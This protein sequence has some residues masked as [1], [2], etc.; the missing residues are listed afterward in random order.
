MLISLTNIGDELLKLSEVD[1]G[2]FIAISDWDKTALQ[3][4]ETARLVATIPNTGYTN[5]YM[6]FMQSLSPI[7]SRITVQ[8]T[9]AEKVAPGQIQSLPLNELSG[10]VAY[11]ISP[12]SNN[13]TYHNVTLSAAD[14]PITTD[15]MPF[16]GT[17][18]YIDLYSSALNSDFNGNIGSIAF[19]IQAL[20]LGV[21]SDLDF[22]GLLSLMADGDSNLVS[23]YKTNVTNLIIVEYISGGFANSTAIE[24]VPTISPIH[25]ALTWVNASSRINTYVNGELRVSNAWNPGLWEGNLD[26]TLC[27]LGKNDFLGFVGWEGYISQYRLY[28]RELSAQEVFILANT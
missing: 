7:N 9:Y 11:D 2:N 26:P 6:D 5:A 25:I 23:I 17:N 3:P 16:F 20:N 21:W 15:R 12:E 18:G 22:M 14:S 1:K 8:F 4:N 10:S 19:F 13:G 28:N 27:L 24:I